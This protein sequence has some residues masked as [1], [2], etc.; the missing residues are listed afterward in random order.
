MASVDRRSLC[1]PIESK[2]SSFHRLTAEEIEVVHNAIT[3]V[4]S[5][6]RGSELR[7]AEAGGR[8]RMVLSGWMAWVA[9]IPDGRRQII[10]LALPGELLDGGPVEGVHV[11]YAP[12]GIAQTGD[13]SRLIALAERPDR[14]YPGL[15]EA[16][17]RARRAAADRMIHHV[18][19]LGRLSA[20]ERTASLFLELHDRQ[21]RSGQADER[22]MPLRL[23]QEV[24]SDILGL[25]AVHVNRILQ[26]LRRDELI[27]FRAGRVVFSDLERMRRAAGQV[28]RT[29]PPP[30]PQGA[31][32]PTA[33]T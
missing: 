25:S 6:Q 15:S 33:Q 5:H 9:H 17:A 26:Q 14:P 10:S 11:G 31:L 19:R 4:H 24:L 2:L 7:A 16:W 18:L 23:T 27:V 28:D 30:Q 1:R 13:A 32:C 12:I 21:R 22:S 8:R 3:D 29:L 20:Y